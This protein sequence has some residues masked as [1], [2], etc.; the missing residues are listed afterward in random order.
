MLSDRLFTTKDTALYSSCRRDQGIVVLH[1][2]GVGDL[3]MSLAKAEEISA[4]LAR[5]AAYGREAALVS[6]YDSSA[7]RKIEEDKKV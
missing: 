4:D 3:P 5:Q 1:I 7:T 2:P 6:F